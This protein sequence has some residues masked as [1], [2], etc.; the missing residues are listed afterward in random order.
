M[1][2]FST[3]YTMELFETEIRSNILQSQINQTEIY[4]MVYQLYGLTD[5]EIKIVEEGI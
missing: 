4:Q 1:A 3:N 5:E 2:E